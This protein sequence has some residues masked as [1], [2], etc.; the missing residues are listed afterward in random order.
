[1]KNFA[2]IGHVDNGKSTLGGHLLYKCNCIT[3]HEMKK[4][5]DDATAKKMERWKYAYLLDI[6]ESERL[7]GKTHE[8][9]TIKFNYQNKQYMLIDTPG[10]K[11]FI[12]SMIGGISMIKNI[13][14]VLVVSLIDNEFE[15]GFERGG[16]IKEDLIIAKSCGI[17]N[18]IIAMNKIDAIDYNEEKYNIIKE[19]LTKFIKNLGFKKITFI[20]IS[21]WTGENLTEIS[22]NTPFYNGKTLMN[23]LDEQC[24]DTENINIDNTD[25]SLIQKSKICVT[26]RFLG[27]LLETSTSIIASGFTG[28]LYY[29]NNE[30]FVEIEKIFSSDKKAIPF[31]KNNDFTK[32]Y[33]VVIKCSEQ[34]NVNQKYDKFLIRNGDDFVGFGNIMNLESK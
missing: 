30:Y 10:H 26:M 34:I 23:L 20:P 31:V 3:E 16:Q 29:D 8:F 7:K 1:M 15:R 28:I 33:I 18:M 22:K 11:S 27:N 13:T 6:D 5:E 17:D 2:L 24:I 19:K 12:R 32:K 4:V 21:G 9:S 14:G 25:T